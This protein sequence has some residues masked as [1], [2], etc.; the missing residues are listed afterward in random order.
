MKFKVNRIALKLSLLASLFILVVIA[1]M[2]W[3]L[4]Q[5]GEQAMI[6]EM[7]FRSVAYARS[8][9]E[10]IFPQLDTF[11]LHFNTQETLKKSNCSGLSL[12]AE[13]EAI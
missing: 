12:R 6:S 11:T 5:Q 2:T 9:G 4:L 8:A 1:A 7:Q 10:A 3:I 13:G